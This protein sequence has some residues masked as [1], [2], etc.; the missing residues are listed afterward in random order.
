MRPV[1]LYLTEDGVLKLGNYG[2]TAQS[3]CYSLKRDC[4]RVRILDLEVYEMKSDVWSFEIALIEAM[5]MTP[6]IRHESDRLPTLHAIAF[7]P[8]RM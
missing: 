1:N 8:F 6:C 3:E 4:I 2:L 5:G 7:F